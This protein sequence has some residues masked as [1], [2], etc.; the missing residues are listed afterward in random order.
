MTSSGNDFPTTSEH[1]K[2]FSMICG[3]KQKALAPSFL[4]YTYL[5][6]VIGL[7]NMRSRQDQVFQGLF[8]VHV[9]LARIKS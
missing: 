2:D 8:W 3:A 5:A 9:K 1:N 4:G 6:E 7:V